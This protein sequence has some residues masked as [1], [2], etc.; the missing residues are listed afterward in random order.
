VVEQGE[1]RAHDPGRHGEPLV[2]V[3]RLPPAVRGPHDRVTGS[4]QGSGD[5]PDR[6]GLAGA[7]RSEHE[8]DRP[9][10][11]QQPVHQPALLVRQPSA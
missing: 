3:L 4:S 10:G 11:A 9:A 1:P 8:L 6:L 2:Q 7:G 5:G